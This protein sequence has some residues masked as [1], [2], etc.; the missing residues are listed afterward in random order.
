MKTKF[1]MI[2]APTNWTAIA[3]TLFSCF[4]ALAVINSYTSADLFPLL[5]L[6]LAVHGFEELRNISMY[7]SIIAAKK[8]DST[9]NSPAAIEE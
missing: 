3:Y 2:N 6:M 4:L 9:N 1:D 8:N 7:L 5:G